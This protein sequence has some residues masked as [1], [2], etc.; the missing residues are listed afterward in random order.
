VIDVIVQNHGNAL[1]D[2]SPLLHPPRALAVSIALY[3]VYAA[4]GRASLDHWRGFVFPV[5]TWILLVASL[6]VYDRVRMWRDWECRDH[7]PQSG[8]RERRVTLIGTRHEAARAV[9]RAQGRNTSEALRFGAWLRPEQEKILLGLFPLIVL[10]VREFMD[11]PMEAVGIAGLAMCAGMGLEVL[12][13][14]E[15]CVVSGRSLTV[16]GLSG[17]RVMHRETFD[18]GTAVVRVDFAA[19]ALMLRQDDRELL[20]TLGGMSRPHALAAA[21]LAGVADAEKGT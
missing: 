3:Y 12:M 20:L 11:L 5:V 18:L 16:E 21:I 8:T 14:R 10:G 1:R 7:R 6:W 13:C 9:A 19:N 4:C 2:P 17:L 15:R